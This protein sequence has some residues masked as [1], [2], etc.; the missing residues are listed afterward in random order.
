MR[1]KMHGGRQV[2]PNPNRVRGL[3]LALAHEEMARPR[4]TPPIDQRRGIACFKTSIL[5]KC[6]ARA[7]PPP[8]MRALSYRR[9]D[10]LGFDKQG[11]KLRR[12]VL[13]GLL[14]GDGRRSGFKA[15]LLQSAIYS[16]KTI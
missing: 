12:Q 10:P 8:P 13:R 15:R 11:R 1:V 4:R 3:P 16:A 6:F 5:P 9:R 2:D 7:W 14:Q